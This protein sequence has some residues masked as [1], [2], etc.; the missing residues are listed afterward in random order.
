MRFTI[1]NIIQNRHIA[2]RA[3][4]VAYVLRIIV[5]LISATN[6]LI[7]KAIVD[8]M[9]L[10]ISQK[11]IFYGFIV[12]FFVATF[13]DQI[14]TKISYLYMSI[15]KEKFFL[16][17][18]KQAFQKVFSM[19][20]KQYVQEWTWKLLKKV[21]RWIE[22]EWRIFESIFQISSVA[23]IRFG[24]SVFVIFYTLPF[25]AATLVVGVLLLL[26]LAK[27]TQKKSEPL[28][29]EVK[30]IW[31]TASR[32]ESKMI[33]EKQLINLSVKEQNELHDYETILQ[34]LQKKSWR[35]DFRWSLPYDLMFVLFRIVEWVG[36]LFIWWQIRHNTATYW[37]V[38]MLIWFVW[39]LRWPFDIIA[40]AISDWSKEKARYESLQDILMQP[41]QVINWYARYIPK[42][43]HISYNKVTFSYSQEKEVINAMTLDIPWGS[44]C[45]LVWHSGSWKSTLIKLLL[46][47]YDVDAW[48]ISIDNQDITSIDKKTLYPYI[49]YLAQEPSIFDGTIRENLLYALSDTT[50]IDES[51]LRDALEKAQIAD[52]IRTLEKWLDT[53]IWER[54]IKLSW[55]E[56]QRLA[57]ARIFLKNPSIL[58]LDEPTSALDSVSEHAITQVMKSL[59][60]C[61]TVV[62]IAHRL[63]TVMHADKI[64]VL[65]KWT[66]VQQGTHA[67]LIEQSW[68]YKTLVDLQSWVIQ[69]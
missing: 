25:A 23:L 37:D 28:Y 52:H 36:Y 62:I 12:L 46:R 17:K 26:W 35:A 13:F 16:S 8:T 19:D 69:E 56:R 2:P 10:W 34:P 50:S 61:R 57:I 54:W 45:A 7:T 63:Q 39:Q 67:Q 22:A 3:I 30:D 21:E 49:W 1:K 44:T 53:E 59:F 9:Q 18:N 4:V 38:I 55:W 24:T 5:E 47:Y 14:L 66:I 43:W 58:I 64:V 20:Y 11:Q 65:E 51:Y 27:I 60:V 6:P 42:S 41:S 33:M 29:K 31:E 40:R 68:V 48:S 32:Q 15:F